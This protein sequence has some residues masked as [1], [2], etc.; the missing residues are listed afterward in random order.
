MI[1]T[2]SGG[3]V[4][5][6]GDAR[7]RFKVVTARRLLVVAECK[8]LVNGGGWSDSNG[9]WDGC[10]VS[11]LWWCRGET[12]VVLS[13][14]G[15]LLGWW[16]KM[17]V[18]VE[19]DSSQETSLFK[20]NRTDFVPKQ[21]HSHEGIAHWCKGSSHSQEGYFPFVRRVCF[22]PVPTFF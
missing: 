15:G 11:Y 16:T 4:L 19:V 8:T 14:Y 9:K 7:W 17:W 12:Y 18:S 20:Q 1:Q 6:Y 22:A 13:G 10:D 21:S 3:W 2:K 5:I